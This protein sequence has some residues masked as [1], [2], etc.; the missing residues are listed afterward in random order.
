MTRG[1][2][3]DVATLRRLPEQLLRAGYVNA[4]CLH[5]PLH[6]RLALMRKQLPTLPPPLRALVSLFLLGDAVDPRALSGAL[7]EGELAALERIGVL[8]SASGSLTTAGMILVPLFGHMVFMPLPESEQPVIDDALVLAARVTPPPRARCLDLCAG[9]GVKALRCLTAGGSVLAVEVNPVLVGCIELNLAVN[10]VG[11]VAEVRTGDLYEALAD[12]ERFDYVAANPPVLAFP[13]H[14]FS[15]AA[16]PSDDGLAVVRRVLDG[17][18]AVLRP[19]G[20]AQI[21]ACSA[22]DESGPVLAAELAAF[23]AAHGARVVSTVPGRLHLRPGAGPLE[24]LAAGTAAFTGLALELVRERL[25]AHV[26]ETGLDYLYAMISTV[27][28]E[29]PGSSTVIEHFREPG[30]FWFK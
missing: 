27:S 12:D 15:P 19:G 29:E 23:A 17:L 13:P 5:G 8:V 14:L 6:L 24:E 21:L 25:S 9:T 18:P 30:G 10:G 28:L 4:Y 26:E 20:W 1:E 11:D 16:D 7:A 22:G 2:D 3:V